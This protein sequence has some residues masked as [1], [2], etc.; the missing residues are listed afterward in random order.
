MKHSTRTDED[1][2]VILKLG[3]THELGFPAEGCDVNLIVE[4]VSRLINEVAGINSFEL[5]QSVVNEYAKNGLGPEG[6]VAVA[7][8]T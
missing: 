1:G 3:L 5:I 7:N 8:D 4:G 2:K 6:W